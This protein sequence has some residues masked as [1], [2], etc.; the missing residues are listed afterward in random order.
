MRHVHRAVEDGDAHLGVA[1]RLSVE[2]LQALQ[3]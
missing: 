3:L 1:E 2:S